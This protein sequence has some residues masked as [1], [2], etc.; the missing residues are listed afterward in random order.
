MKILSLRFKNINSLKGEWKIDFTRQPFRDTGLFAITG[1][2]GAGKTT[3]L[4]AIC[5]ALYH[6]TPRLSTISKSSNELM[7]RGTA[8]SLAEVEF[9]VKGVGYRAF[10]S[11]RRS[12]G[13]VDGNLQDAQVEL[14]KLTDD[15]DEILASQ[16]KR[17]NELVDGITGLNFARFTKSMMLSQG[18]FAAF[19]NADAGDR[20]DLLEELTGTEIYGLISEQVYEKFSLSKQHLTNL[21]ARAEGVELKS[22]QELQTLTEQQLAIEQELT[23]LEHKV[24]QAQDC[25]NWLQ[26]LIQLH[27]RAA[28]LEQ[29][30]SK[31]QAARE[32]NKPELDKLA[33]A[34]PAARL[35]G[36]FQPLCQL[37]QRLEQDKAQHLQLQEQGQQ[38]QAELLRQ[39]EVISGAQTRQ[40]DAKAVLQQMRTLVDD[41]L[42]P[43]DEQFRNLAERQ[44]ELSQSQSHEQ[45]LL[46]AAKTELTDKQQGITNLKTS[47]QQ[48]RAQLDAYPHG[49][50]IEANISG[51]QHQ[52]QQLAGTGKELEQLNRQL[53]DRQNAL[54]TL[55]ERFNELQRQQQQ[56]ELT[57]TSANQA[58]VPLTDVMSR[59][60]GEFDEAGLTRELGR[61]QQRQPLLIKMQAPIKDYRQLLAEDDRLQQ[62]LTGSAAEVARWQ[63]ER[64]QLRQDFKQQSAHLEDVNKLIEQEQKIANLSQ[65]RASLELD[66]ACPLC[67]STQ[68]PLVDDYQALDVNETDLRRQQLQQQ[69][70][71][72]MVQ[73]KALARMIEQRQLQDQTSLER[74]NDIQKEMQQAVSDFEQLK[75]QLIALGDNCEYQLDRPELVEAALCESDTQLASLNERLSEF[76]QAQAQWQQRQQELVRLQTS[77]REVE[78]NRAQLLSEQEFVQQGI[79]EL[80]AR[81]SQLSNQNQQQSD[82]LSNTLSSVGL[83]LPAAAEIT[84]WADKLTAEQ[85]NWKRVTAELVENEKQLLAEERALPQLEKQAAQLEESAA[86][87]V[88]ALAKVGAEIQANRDERLGLAGEQTQSELIGGKQL[89]VD[90][91]TAELDSAKNAADELSRN[92]ASTQGQQ[93]T[94]SG[95]IQQLE[96]E[97]AELSHNWQQKLADSEFADE[98]DFTAALL[99]DIETDRLI[100]LRKQIET[101]VETAQTETRV[102]QEQLQQL[103]QKG[104]QQGYLDSEQRTEQEYLAELSQKLT[105][106]K[107]SRDEGRMRL[108][109]VKAIIA[110]DGRRREGQQQLFTQIEAATAEYEDWDALNGL[111][112]A[113]DGKKFRVFAQGLTLDHLVALANRQL[114]RLH[115]RYELKRKSAGVLEL[116]VLDTWQ[117]DASR[118]TRTLSGGESFLVSLALA[119]ALSDLVS[120]KTS[121]DSLFL[122]EGF[123]TLDA[124]TLDMALDALDN[125]NASGKMIGVISH[126]EAMKERIP[127]QIKVRKMTGLGYS[128]LDPRFKVTAVEESLV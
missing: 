119:L 57:L 53:A 43:L 118:D 9:E 60:L 105:E 66:Q 36:Y 45:E 27:E 20:A 109:E 116:E 104:E 101:S 58:S 63:R 62:T 29:A 2:T 37:T 74:R 80:D 8:E 48:L 68:H 78:H 128:Q 46:Q 88:A 124:D 100:A 91:A 67:G 31:A 49:D 82:A 99:D 3:I 7:T 72:I 4:D 30:L 55:P 112:G 93:Q 54:Q 97:Q 87:K 1:P 73:G 98:A 6:Q 126:V 83:S 125:L 47:A 65:L 71:E 25:H 56:A 41:K 96:A 64:E 120:H 13:K 121:I 16:V 92:L 102:V 18:Q 113:R 26:Q 79:A 32:Q 12:R 85:A 106:A 110:E 90:T 35:N 61:L 123:G 115:G 122:D 10:W 28:N 21:K 94:L 22:E 107:S 111:I 24:Q 39:Q 14:A 75:Q 5:L 117:G 23:E 76:R 51:W 15:G 108:G 34:E 40:T 84:A 11:Q 52:L 114:T 77:L 69:V 38:L 127:V 44:Q 42:A 17:K 50:L 103:L 95:N 81:A 19:L 86:Q 59:A 33:R 70:N 89:L